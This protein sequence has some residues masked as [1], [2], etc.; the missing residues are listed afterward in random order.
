MA[1]GESGFDLAVNNYY[2]F[3]AFMGVYP[4]GVY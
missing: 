4:G 1:S 3:V 2:I